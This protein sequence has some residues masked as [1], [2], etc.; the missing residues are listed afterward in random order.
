MG[1]YPSTACASS[2][3]AARRPSSSRTQSHLYNTKALREMHSTVTRN[4]VKRTSPR[5]RGTWR[6]PRCTSRRGMVAEATYKYMQLVEESC[7]PWPTARNRSCAAASRTPFD[8]RWSD[9]VDLSDEQARGG[10]PR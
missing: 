4:L 5:A 1:H 10:G 3:M 7:R 6:P 9:L 8:H 2:R